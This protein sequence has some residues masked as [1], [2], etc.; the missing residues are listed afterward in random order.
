MTRRR[1]SV[2][3]L[4]QSMLARGEEVEEQ[5]EEEMERPAQ[6]LENFQLGLQVDFKEN[7]GREWTPLEA[8]TDSDWELEF[9]DEEDEFD[10]LEGE[11]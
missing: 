2:H 7:T 1:D 3:E 11:G 8:S 10:W 9:Y 6:D 4:F 5:E